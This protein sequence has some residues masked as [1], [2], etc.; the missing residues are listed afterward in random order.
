[1]TPSAAFQLGYDAYLGSYKD[2]INPFPEGT[3]NHSYWQD[4]FNSAQAD[5]SY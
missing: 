4:G 1:M 3:D 2:K 5:F